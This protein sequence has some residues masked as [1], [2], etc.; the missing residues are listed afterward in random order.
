MNPLKLPPFWFLLAVLAQFGIGWL[1]DGGADGWAWYAAGYALLAVGMFLVLGAW[2]SFRIHDTP[3]CPFKQPT[4]LITDGVFRISRNPIY[5]GQVI[6][7]LGLASL[8]GAWLTLLPIPLLIVILH[9]GF[10]RPEERILAQQCGPE[11]TAYRQRV[12]AWL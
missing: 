9:F 11:F 2:M 6:M 10:I 3:I 8:H 7:L 1:A 12:R 4:H 5:L